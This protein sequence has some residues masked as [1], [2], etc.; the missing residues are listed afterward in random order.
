MAGI[1]ITDCSRGFVIATGECRT[2]AGAS[3]SLQYG[4]I[5]PQAEIC[6]GFGLIGVF[7]GQKFGC[8]A[9][10][11]I[12][13]CFHDSLILPGRAGNVEQHE[14]DARRAD[15]YE[16]AKI[17]EPAWSTINRRQ[18]TIHHLRDRSVFGPAM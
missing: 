2:G 15:A 14:Q 5:Q 16:V 13:R 17:A 11:N 12:L 4:G 6:H 3:G 8:G 7:S 18:L 10:K 1:E 9:T